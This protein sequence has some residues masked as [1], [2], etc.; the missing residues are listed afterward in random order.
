MQ[1]AIQ[2]HSGEEQGGMKIAIQGHRAGGD[3]ERAKGL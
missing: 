1:S 2:G 3:E